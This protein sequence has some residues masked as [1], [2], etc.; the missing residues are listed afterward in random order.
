MDSKTTSSCWEVQWAQANVAL[1]LSIALQRQPQTAF[2]GDN[3][4]VHLDHYNEAAS[5]LAEAR[6]AREKSRFIE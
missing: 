6:V 4:D 2:F 5:Y 1:L 3:E